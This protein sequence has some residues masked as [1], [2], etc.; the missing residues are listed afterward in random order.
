MKRRMKEI[1]KIFEV[2]IKKFEGK[3]KDDLLWKNAKYSPNVLPPIKDNDN[4]NNAD[5]LDF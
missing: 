4:K 3:E 2:V 1:D 5:K